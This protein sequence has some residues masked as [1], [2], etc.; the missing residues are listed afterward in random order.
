MTA[1]YDFYDYRPSVISARK[2]KI[3]VVIALATIL[4][5][6]NS[7]A[8]DENAYRTIATGNFQNPAIWQRYSGGV[9]LA[10]TVKPDRTNDIYIE[11][12]HRVIM[13]Q[14]EEVKNI[15]LNA[16]AGAEQKLNINGHFIEVYGSLNAYTGNAP[17]VPRG[18]FIATDW[19]GNSITSRLVFKGTS[20]VIIAAGAWSAQN[21]NSRYTVIFDPDED[22]ELIIERPFKAN[23]FVFRNGK[24]IQKILEG[25]ECAT[26]SFNTNFTQFPG[27]YGNVIIESG[28]TLI[29]ECNNNISIRSVNS[30]TIGALFDLMEGGRLVIK[31]NQPQIHAA[32]VRYNGTVVYDGNMGNQQFITS[33]LAMVQRQYHHLHFKGLANKIMPP[34]LRVVGN[35]IRED[36]SGSVTDSATD[37]VLTGASDQMIYDPD[38]HPTHFTLDKTDGTA[39][40]HQDLRIRQ[41]FNMVQGSM[42]FMGNDLFFHTTFIGT[43]S[44]G[45][46]RWLNLRQLNYLG[47]PTSLNEMNAAFPFNDD[48]VGGVRKLM[49]LGNTGIISSM[50]IRYVQ[51][52]GVNW[53]PGFEDHDST[54]I[55]YKTN[56]YFEFV[57]A[58]VSDNPLEMLIDA[59]D[60]IVL[61]P[62]HLRI[63]SHEGPAP[64][65]H[66]EGLEVEQQFLARRGMV[67]ADLNGQTFAIGSVGLPS[68]L[69]L[70]WS[71]LEGKATK[72]GV[73]LSW[74]QEISTPGDRYLIR[75]SLND[76]HNLKEIGFGTMEFTSEGEVKSLF[77]DSSMMR[78]GWI[79]YQIEKLGE[80]GSSDFSPVIR[81]NWIQEKQQL[82]KVYPIPYISGTLV[83]EL[84]ENVKADHGIVNIYDKGGNN[85]FHYEG[86]LGLMEEML[87][88]NLKLYSPG[89]YLIEVLTAVDR[90]TVKW[91]KK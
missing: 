45:S 14:N 47:T 30:N 86:V 48:E 64:G 12:P 61:D 75:R 59:D 34:N 67:F 78:S 55:L 49:L 27:I 36:G 22:A 26:F 24:V 60:L 6:E 80:N 32:E 89:L 66:L 40:L 44:F 9:W 11:N 53:S 50:R 87:T 79:Y 62:V 90:Q 2:Y 16:D 41:N 42:D 5:S 68:I 65:E 56:S 46:G 19:I 17:G 20:R 69:P 77:L 58:P 43:Y 70:L 29:S 83:F 52:P 63:V 13:T 25:G 73:L 3:I 28:G 85:I 84:L 81:V 33:N 38:F 21:T 1:R 39:Y 35:F 88:N 37:F 71:E 10:A 91:I 4:F 31:G 8:Q 76:I 7:M 57:E 15:F 18:S 51:N 23:Q 74:R 54:P 72:E 82:F